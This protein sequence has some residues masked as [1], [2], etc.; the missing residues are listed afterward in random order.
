MFFVRSSVKYVERKNANG[1]AE[2]EFNQPVNMVNIITFHP[3]STKYSGSEGE[4]TEHLIKFR[5]VEDYTINWV[6]TTAEERDADFNELQDSVL[7]VRLGEVD[8]M[9]VMKSLGQ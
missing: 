5:D 6:Y 7:S 2:R 4:T 9:T 8:K 3:N 1:I